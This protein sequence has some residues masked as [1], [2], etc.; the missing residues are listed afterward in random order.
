MAREDRASRVAHVLKFAYAM[1][2]RLLRHLHHHTDRPVLAP[3]DDKRS[4]RG[5]IV[6]IGVAVPVLPHETVRFSSGAL[7]RRDVNPSDKPTED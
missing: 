2:P 4:T 5:P 1:I 3:L 6:A 7:S